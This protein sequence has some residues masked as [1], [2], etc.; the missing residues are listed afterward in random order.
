MGQSYWILGT[1]NGWF[2]VLNTKN[3]VVPEPERLDPDPFDFSLRTFEVLQQMCVARK[4]LTSNSA[5]QER[6]AALDA[7]DEK[8]VRNEEVCHS[9]R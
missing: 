4:N 8:N 5:F 2:E 9:A 3:F 6:T 7:E 1:L